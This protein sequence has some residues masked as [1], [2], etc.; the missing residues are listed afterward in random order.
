M[1]SRSPASWANDIV[2]VN[3]SGLNQEEMEVIIDRRKMP[4]IKSF[5]RNG[6]LSR[7][8]GKVFIKSIKDISAGS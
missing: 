8:D 7:E 2:D 3:L 4:I 1:I 5:M 6:K